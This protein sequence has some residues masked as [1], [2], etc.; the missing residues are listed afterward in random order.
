MRAELCILRRIIV[1]ETVVGGLVRSGEVRELDWLV[2]YCMRLR[3]GVW[4]V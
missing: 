4:L 2:K 3:C 1:V